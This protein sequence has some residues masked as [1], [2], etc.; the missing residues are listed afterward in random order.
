MAG[1][2]SL[3]TPSTGLVTLTPTDTATDKTIT[4]PATTGTVVIQDGTSTATVVNL[5]Y[6][7]TLTGGTGVVNLGSGQ[8][9]KD[10]LGQLGVGTASPGYR[11]DVAA[12]D[13]TANFGYALRLR[14]NATATAATMQFT[15]SGVTTENGYIRVTDTGLMSFSNKAYITSAGDVG[16]GTSTPIAKLDVNKAIFARPTATNTDSFVGAV[17]FD[18]NSTFTNTSLV[19]YGSTASGTTKGLAN[20]SLGVLQFIN[21]SAGLIQTNGTS[22]IVFGT[23]ASEN[24]RLTSDGNLLVGTTSPA[25][26]SQS[27]IVG[28]SA[29]GTFSLAVIHNAADSAVRGILSRCPNYSGDDGY[30]FIGNRVVSDVIYIK[31]NGNVLNLNNSYG[32]LSDIKLKENIVPASSKLDNLMQVE[33]VNYNLKDQPEQKLLGVVA[34]QLEQVFPSMVEETSD[35]DVDGKDLGTKTKSVKYSVFVPMLIKA[36]QEQQT[37]IQDLTTRLNTLEGN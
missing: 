20:A 21:C 5:A 27:T 6:T 32:A 17:T 23:V 8:V 37:L 12:G 34:Q 18:Y 15:N 36:I 30:L 10:A 19:Q 13:T 16:I 29:G 3:K 22:P 11:L 4:L 31:T 1:V 28:P 9:Y 2:L 7:G 33:I 14:S 35:R 25:L 26:N 24:M